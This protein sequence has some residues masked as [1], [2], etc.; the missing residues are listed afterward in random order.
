MITVLA[1][2]L[3]GWAYQP[4][5][6]DQTSLGYLRSRNGQQSITLESRQEA[7]IRDLST[8]TH[9]EDDAI[10]EAVKKETRVELGQNS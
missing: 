5:A 1:F 4:P 7:I 10:E 2:Q 8:T 3:A 6:G 9:C